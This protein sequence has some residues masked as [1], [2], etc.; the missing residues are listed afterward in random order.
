L[1]LGLKFAH[2]IN[3]MRKYNIIAPAMRNDIN[4]LHLHAEKANEEANANGRATVN[5][6]ISA[7][8]KQNVKLYLE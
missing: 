7:S 1:Q 8:V 2:A 5:K 3:D 6:G 4:D